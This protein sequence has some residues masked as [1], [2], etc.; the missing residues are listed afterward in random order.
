MSMANTLAQPKRRSRNRSSALKSQFPI[1]TLSLLTSL[2]IAQSLLNLFEALEPELVII[3]IEPY[4]IVR[5]L[6]R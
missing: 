6:F 4:F 1:A 2:L 3:N 5:L